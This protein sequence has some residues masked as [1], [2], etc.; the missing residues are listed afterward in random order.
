MS[1][2]V[3]AL[4]HMRHRLVLEAPVETPDGAG[5]IMRAW[6][7]VATV[8]A[9]IEPLEA[10]F[11]LVGEA[12]GVNATHVITIRWRADVTSGHRLTKGARVFVILGFRDPN[13]NR[14]RL[15]LTVEERKA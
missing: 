9:A 4:G 2:P 7:A 3:S 5:G 12:P 11:S 6:Q 15:L 13:E 1:G 10:R 8:W 14:N